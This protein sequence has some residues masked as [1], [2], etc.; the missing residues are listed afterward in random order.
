MTH[1]DVSKPN[2]LVRSLKQLDAVPRFARGWARNRVLRRAVQVTDESGTEP[3]A[4]EFIWAW[5]PSG[6][7]KS[8]E[9]SGDHVRAAKPAR[10]ALN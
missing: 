2:R 6:P 1:A 9:T 4:C 8:P 3:I 5:I 7:R 10:A